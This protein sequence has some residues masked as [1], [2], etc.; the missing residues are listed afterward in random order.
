MKYFTDTLKYIKNNAASWVAFVVAAVA[1]AAIYDPHALKVVADSADGGHVNAGIGSWLM[2]FLPVNTSAWWTVLISF[3]G[4]IVLI[5]DLAFICATTDRRMRYGSRSFRGILSSMNDSAMPCAAVAV[6]LLTSLCILSVV[7]AAIMKA[8][9]S[10]G[11]P[12]MYIGGIALCAV[13]MLVAVYALTFF[14][15]WL[16]C[17]AITGFRAYE[18]FGYSYSLAAHKRKQI[19]LSVYIPIIV[20]CILSAAIP[21]LCSPAVTTALLPL[22]QAALYVYTAINSFTMYLDADGTEREDLKK[23]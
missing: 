1:F 13:V 7:M 18:S 3:A 12:Y 11:A 14:H 15:L 4:Y 21:A 20:V 19:F 8:S 22:F 6:F 10:F 17:F 5:A 23:F 9:C 2:L 16:P